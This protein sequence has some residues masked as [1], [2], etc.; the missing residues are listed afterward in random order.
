MHFFPE[1]SS[2]NLESIVLLFNICESE[3]F[4]IEQLID[5]WKDLGNNCQ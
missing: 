1:F 4:S 5:I 3:E 2:Y